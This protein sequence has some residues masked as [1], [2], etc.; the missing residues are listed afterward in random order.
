MNRLLNSLKTN[1]MTIIVALPLNS[2]EMATA[3]EANGAQAIKTHLN[4]THR[5][6]RVNFGS[7]EDERQVLAE[8]LASVAIPV[9]IVPGASLDVGPELIA[10]LA[11]MGFDYF[12]IFA[13][14]MRPELLKVPGISRMAAVDSSMDFQLIA[15]LA[16]SE[17]E[18]ME[19][20]IIAPEGY[21][22][23]LSAVDL[24]RYRILRKHVSIPLIIPSQ[25]TIKPQDIPSLY[26][27]GVEAVLVGVLST[28]K[29]A[30]Q[31]SRQV[32]AFREAVEKL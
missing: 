11:E 8:I 15:E 6:S 4:M 17:I 1:K 25:R 32:A 3:A 28:G 21:G 29:D 14:F 9:G 27:I 10:E 7:L 23:E 5:A 18:M 31:L 12:D 24:A 16:S 2:V 30:G 26:E 20:A 22:A 19:G 13:H